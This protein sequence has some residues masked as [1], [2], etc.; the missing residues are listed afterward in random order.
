MSWRF[1]YLPENRL[2][3]GGLCELRYPA[4]YV[5]IR[6]RVPV[7]LLLQPTAAINT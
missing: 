3:L 7:A 5:R 1:H 4:L 2:Y 6:L